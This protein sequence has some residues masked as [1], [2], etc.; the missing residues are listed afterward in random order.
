M[1]KPWQFDDDNTFSIDINILFASYCVLPAI[2]AKGFISDW[3]NNFSI[4][5][6]NSFLKSIAWMKTWF[7]YMIVELLGD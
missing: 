2:L 5:I 4:C 1:E 7:F 6:V 3:Y